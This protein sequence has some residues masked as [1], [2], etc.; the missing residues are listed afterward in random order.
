[1]GLLRK[2]LLAPVDLPIT[3]A[4]TLTRYRETGDFR[5]ENFTGPQTRIA[6]DPIAVPAE[7]GHLEIPALPPGSAEIYV[8]E[9][10]AFGT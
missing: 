10:A 7:A 2:L 6:A 1:M 9:G 4:Q 3:G 5:A 8:F